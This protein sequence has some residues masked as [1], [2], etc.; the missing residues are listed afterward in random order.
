MY[1]ILGAD[2]K[3]YGPITAEQL[4]QW[5]AE[6]RVNGQ[7]KILTE[8]ATEW[9]PLAEIPELAAVSPVRPAPLPALQPDVGAAAAKVKGPAIA[10]LV[11]AV[12][13]IL[14]YL[15]NC[16][17][18]VAGVTLFKQELPGSFPPELRAVLEGMQGPLAVF[19][20]LALV[21]LNAFV[22]FGAIKMLK[23]KS[24]GFAL[25][26]CIV[27]MLPCQ[28]CCVLGLP[29]GIWGL[30]VLLKPEVKAAFGGGR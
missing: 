9:K 6:G 22:L 18:A 10:L 29:F 2:G 20:S 23:L 7:T 4:R 17:V 21:A 25:A 12:L 13:G 5:I 1:K 8:G 16:V 3:E 19:S 30:V 11:T 24:H 14:Y 27:A 15:V 28:C 26:A